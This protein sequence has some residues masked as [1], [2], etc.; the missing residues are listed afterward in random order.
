MSS[1]FLL[2]AGSAFVAAFL[3]VVLGR[4][5][6]RAIFAAL[7]AVGLV[8]VLL[9]GAAAGFEALFLIASAALALGL[10]Q[11]FGWMLVDVDR[12]HLPSTDAATAAARSIAFLL[13][14]GGLALLARGVGS[15]M[16]SIGGRAAAAPVH[17]LALGRRLFV[18]Q[19]EGA[20]LLGLLLAAVLLAALMLLRDSPEAR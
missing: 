13:V 8:F 4:N 2:G 16:S 17:A 10:V 1:V 20:L 11:L 19:P 7:V 5:L 14:G 18:Q 3:A 6:T 15:E 12:D 9:V